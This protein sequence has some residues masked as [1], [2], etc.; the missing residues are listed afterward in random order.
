[1]RLESRLALR[2]P[3]LSRLG[4]GLIGSGFILVQLRQSGLFSMLIRQLDQS[5]FS[6]ACGS[7]TVTTPALRLRLAVP[8][9]HHVRVL[10]KA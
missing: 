5:F 8:V 2:V 7:C 9:G 1:M 6:G 10:P 4:N 3:V